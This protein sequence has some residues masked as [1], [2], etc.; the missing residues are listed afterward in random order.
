M[1][2][3]TRPC[4]SPPRS[5]FDFDFAETAPHR[6]ARDSGAEENE[7]LKAAF[8]EAARYDQ[9]AQPQH[10]QG[11]A[12]IIAAASRVSANQGTTPR[13]EMCLRSAGQVFGASGEF[14]GEGA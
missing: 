13:S 14:S 10:V 2:T 11:P 7:L 8:G 5:A 4:D 12:R 1:P 9:S 6:S 3:E